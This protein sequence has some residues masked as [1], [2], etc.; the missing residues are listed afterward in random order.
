MTGPVICRSCG[1][2]WPRHPALEVA[3][4]DCGASV[5]VH[6]KKPSG[7]TFWKSALPHVAREQ[8][9]LDEGKMHRCRAARDE[10]AAAVGVAPAGETSGSRA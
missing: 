9:A 7:H 5:G 1:E 10:P 2:E 6:C 3:C 8:R 4:P